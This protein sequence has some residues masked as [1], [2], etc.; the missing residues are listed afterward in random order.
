MKSDGASVRTSKGRPPAARIAAF[1]WAATPSR[2]LK[3]M[4]ISEEEFTTAI[5][6][7]AMS[8]SVRPR[9]RHCA[10]RMAQRVVPGSKLLRSSRVMS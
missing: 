6:G 5:L 9:A 8:S 2:W 3:Q 10:R 7:L 4:E 1:T